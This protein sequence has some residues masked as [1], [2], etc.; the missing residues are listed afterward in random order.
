MM[1]PVI[2]LSVRDALGV[3]DGVAWYGVTRQSC[4]AECRGP[5]VK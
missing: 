1:R 2:R 5:G 3:V 4:G